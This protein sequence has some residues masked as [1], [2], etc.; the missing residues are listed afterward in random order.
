MQQARVCKKQRLSKETREEEKIWFN[1]TIESERCIT[2]KIKRVEEDKE[3]K[4]ILE[5]KY[6]Q[7]QDEKTHV[8]NILHEHFDSVGRVSITGYI[9]EITVHDVT[10]QLPRIK[11][12]KYPGPDGM[13]QDILKILGTDEQCTKVLT[14][15]LNKT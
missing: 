9:E 11:E 4:H 1:K 5:E 6:R 7:F 14:Y 8:S 13:K 2:D 12:K 15:V 10:Q 3:K